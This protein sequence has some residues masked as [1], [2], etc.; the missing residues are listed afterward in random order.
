MTPETLTKAKA[1]YNLIEQI[2]PVLHHA[3]I[4]TDLEIVALPAKGQCPVLRV[5]RNTRSL[6]IQILQKALTE[7]ESE[8]EKL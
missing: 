8:L 5:D 2:G 1:L 6:I 7:A 4:G 3:N